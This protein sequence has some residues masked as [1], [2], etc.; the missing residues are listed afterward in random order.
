MWSGSVKSKNI[1]IVCKVTEEQREI[2]TGMLGGSAS[3]A[4]V[5]DA[6][7][8]DRRRV[9]ASSEILIAWSP[10]KEL[11]PDEYATIPDVQLIQLITAGVDHLPFSLLPRTASI[12]ANVGAF[13]GPMSEHVLAMTLALAKKLPI[14]HAKL[15]A[16]E[17]DQVTQNKALSGAVCG[18]LGFGGIGRASAH[19]MRLLGMKIYAINTSGRSSDPVDFIGDLT[20]MEYVLRNCDVLLISLPLTKL[21]K[22]LIGARELS[23][24][25]SDAILI[26]VARGEIVDENALYEHLKSHP[27]FMAGIDTWWIEPATHGEFRTNCPFFDLPNILGSPHNSPI[28]P[29]TLIH[30]TRLAAENVLHFLK[31]EEIK[32]IVRREEYE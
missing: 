20:S 6:L 24:M 17:F 7:P 8:E 12:A 30:A 31:G 18:V 13:A 1:A 28:V 26:N 32:G 16:G 5:A 2:L 21:T 22:G 10:S 27:D 19:L 23:W 15:A 9:L 11:H 14:N 25:K 3:L 29:G 4:F